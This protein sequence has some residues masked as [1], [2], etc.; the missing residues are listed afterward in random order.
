MLAACLFFSGATALV[1]QVVWLRMLTL[2]FGHTV[3]A[4]TTVLAAFMAGLAVG[5]LVMGRRARQ[6]SDPL[7]AYAWLEIGI[8]VYAAALPWLFELGSA[9]YLALGR[10][11]GVA[12][13]PFAMAQFLIVF[14]LLFAPTALMGATL[15]V[16][17]QA[18]G[19]AGGSPGRLVGAL[20]AINTFGAVFGV[21]VAGYGLL[22]AAG[23]RITLWAAAAVNVL[24]GVVVLAHVRPRL[25]LERDAPARGATGARPRPGA[26]TAAAATEWRAGPILAALGVSGAVSMLYELAWTRAL[27]LVI[28]S[29]TYAFTAMLLSVLLGIAGGSALY[30]RLAVAHPA[31]PATFAALQLGIAAAVSLTVWAF[32][33]MPEVYLVALAWSAS[34][35]FV[36]LLQIAI[37]VGILLVPSLLIG[38]TFPC[39]LAVSSRGVERVA[40]DVGALYAANTL[41]AIAGVMVT[42][43]A[44][45]PSLGVHDSLRLGVAANLLLA[46][47]LWVIAPR[48]RAAAW[49]AGLGAA[50]ALAG[51]TALARP[52]DPSVMASGPA[53][54]GTGA[55]RWAGRDRFARAVRETSVVYYRDGLTGT[56]S[57][58]RKA[59]RLFLR[60][61]G[62]TDAGTGGDMQTQVMLG[63]LPL[64]AHPDPRRVLVI[65]LGSGITP[66]A[67][68]RHPVEALEVVEIEP[69]VLE[70]SRFFAA[71][72]GDV[73]A[74]PRVRTVLADARAH[75]LT[76]PDRYSVIVSEPSNP[77]I[78][79]LA[80]LFS[81]EFF[82][83]ARSR[84]DPGGIMMQWLQAY[85]LLPEDLRMVVNTFRTVFPHTSVW[86]TAGGDLLLLGRVEPA[87][88]DLRSIRSRYEARPRLREDLERVG[89]RAWPNLLGLFRLGEQDTAQLAAG[90]GLNADD[91]LP[92]EFSAPRALYLD[93]T[94]RNLELLRSH[95]TSPLPEVT[96]DSQAELR[97]A[98]VRFGIAMGYHGQNAPDDALAELGRALALEPGYVPALF[99]AGAI[100]VQR[101]RHAEAMAFL[102]RVHEL[103]P[104]NA[105]AFLLAGLAA[106]GQGMPA[107]AVRF[108]ERGAA[109]EPASREIGAALE[110]ARAAAAGR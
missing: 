26:A 25:R 51:V 66:G 34:T 90:A 52:W 84:L 104:G 45:I 8:G 16:V 87:A 72:H 106:L 17:S 77:W 76:R 101:G 20:Y 32:E 35:A 44:L 37:S 57:V 55:L 85:D 102:R 108:L 74:D 81:V 5:S 9:L 110:R 31:S 95:R 53:I 67:V 82:R 59:D 105:Q 1:Y 7:A 107:D 93:T 23:N 91:R 78:S 4:I 68:A 19:R 13:G 2:V 64:L 36:R 28:G 33:L 3:H 65:G 43:F 56:V 12:S 86:G 88:L 79:G 18:L 50:V 92:L 24:L 89:L 60:I 98:E 94:A 100:R 63:H 75:L 15:P 80:A 109:L 73:L 103:D 42:G 99:W 6:V 61:N 96:P 62:K 48:P 30:A 14:L 70:A 69:A 22:P 11:L 46:V 47:A 39:A 10:A 83:L 21:A 29:S 54:Y 71:L 38:A 27:A 40:A 49:W 41:G 58:H 97:R